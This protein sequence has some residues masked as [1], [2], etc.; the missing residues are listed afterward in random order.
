MKII[1][2]YDFKKED[3]SSFKS[4]FFIEELLSKK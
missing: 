2:I 3:I 1:Y 4:E